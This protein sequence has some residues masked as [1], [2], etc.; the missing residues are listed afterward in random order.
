[1]GGI[2]RRSFINGGTAALQNQARQVKP[3]ASADASNKA[4]V[5]CRITPSGNMIEPIYRQ[6]YSEARSPHA[7]SSSTT[8]KAIISRANPTQCECT[9]S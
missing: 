7:T 8:P 1:M 9:S 4:C 5:V 2:A 6:R 3:T